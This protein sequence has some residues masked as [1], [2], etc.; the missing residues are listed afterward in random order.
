ML[1]YVRICG[2]L[3][4]L[5]SWQPSVSLTI[6]L[7]RKACGEKSSKLVW[8]DEMD[9]E[10][11][12]V[13]ALMQTQIKLS[14]YDE[15]KQLCLIIDG[16]S[17]VGTGFVLT[18]FIDEKNP[19]AGVMIIHC[20]AALLP[21]GDYSPVEGESIALDRAVIA[22]DHW[23]YHNPNKTSLITDC[24]SLE[25]LLDRGLGEIKNKRLQK[26]MERVSP[27]NFEV[28]HIPGVKNRVCD[29]L[30][31]MCK[32]VA[33]YSHLYPTRAPRL[34][35]LSKKLAKRCKQVEIHDP[36]V[37]ELAEIAAGDIEYLAMVKDIEGNIPSKELSEDSELRQL[38][39]SREEI[40]VIQLGRGLRLIVRDESEILVPKS[41]RNR[42]MQNLHLVH[43]GPESML[44]QAKK[45]IF[46]P[47]LKK[48]LQDYYEQCEECRIYKKSK[49]NAGNEVSFENLF[50]LMEPGT[51]VEVDYCDFKSESY[52]VMADSVSGFIQTYRTSGKTCKEAVRCIREWGSN[53]GKP[54]ILKTDFGPSY[55]DS[56]RKEC[57][58]LGIEVIHSSSYN[59]QSQGLV[60][61]AVQSVKNL[62][63]KSSGKLTQ[64]EL[65]E[66][67]FA[68]NA[69]E[70]ETG[71]NLS[72][73][74]GRGLRTHIPN[75]L[76]RSV[77]FRELIKERRLAREKRV[78]KKQRTEQK[79]L[80]FVPGEEVWIQCPKTN[81]WNIKGEIVSPRTAA[82]GTIL[83]WE[84]IF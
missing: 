52:L 2:F 32:S 63:K 33:G 57:W 82:D 8:N 41:A 30:S 45:K 78:R 28:N 44:F 13:L 29:Y 25:G 42:M 70:S 14:P 54:Y 75:S 79:K 6:P 68:L 18:Q 49:A 67:V 10:Y 51:L 50:D 71:S 72:R 65:S 20:G 34:I 83:S 58:D 56:F 46:W 22:C 62:L 66:M 55:R 80:I 73:F 53:F 77:N 59:S 15:T 16:T 43:S 48:D 24:A 38:A 36:L 37:I 12:E 4:S 64:L 21:P 47:G 60:E 74:I 69:K 40:K 11:N 81:L 5:Q 35:S 27:Y 39:A 3:S 17:K 76:D 23:I 7:L 26:I 84:R 19:S 31:R 1:G 9:V 61:R